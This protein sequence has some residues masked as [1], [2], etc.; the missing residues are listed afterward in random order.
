MHFVYYTS[1]PSV[2]IYISSFRLKCC[3]FGGNHSRVLNEFNDFRQQKYI[4]N[5]GMVSLQGAGN[6][7]FLYIHLEFKWEGRAW[8]IKISFY[9]DK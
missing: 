1:V 5:I 6:R 8:I 3:K 2:A 9:D 7:Y 4:R